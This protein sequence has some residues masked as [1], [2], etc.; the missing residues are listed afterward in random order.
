[1]DHRENRVS[2]TMKISQNDFG[3]LYYNTNT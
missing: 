3:R 2:W 1:M